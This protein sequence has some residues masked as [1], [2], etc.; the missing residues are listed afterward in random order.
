MGTLDAI[1]QLP[2]GKFH[3]LGDDLLRRLDSRYRRLRTH[4]VNDR[5]E[6]IKGQPDSYVGDTADTS[7][8][9]VC[10]TVQR[11]GWWRKIVEDIQ[12]AVDACPMATEV[13]AVIPHNA[14]ETGRRTRAMSGFRKHEQQPEKPP[15]V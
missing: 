3:L 14:D 7:C 6:S 15:F 9:A 4:G 5:G 10:Y 12:E 1:K 11:S 8:V 13:I 2:D